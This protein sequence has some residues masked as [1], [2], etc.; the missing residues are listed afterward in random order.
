MMLWRWAFR[1]SGEGRNGNSA[2]SG[3]EVFPDGTMAYLFCDRMII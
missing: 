1:V 3:T 2:V